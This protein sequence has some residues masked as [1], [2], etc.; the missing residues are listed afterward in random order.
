MIQYAFNGLQERKASKNEQE[1]LLSQ[2]LTQQKWVGNKPFL[3]TLIFKATR[4]KTYAFN[5]ILNNNINEI[6]VLYGLIIHGYCDEST[7][8]Y[9]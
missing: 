1:A 2:Y 3:K 4:K 9:H 7:T 5:D 8:T 6:T